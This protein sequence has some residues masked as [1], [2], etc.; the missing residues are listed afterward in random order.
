MWLILFY[1]VKRLSIKAIATS[2]G[3]DLEKGV[4]FG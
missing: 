4:M 3:V 2:D 1:L